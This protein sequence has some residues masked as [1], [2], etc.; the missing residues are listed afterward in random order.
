MKIERYPNTQRSVNARYSLVYRFFGLLVLLVIATQQNAYTSSITLSLKPAPPEAIRA[1]KKEY[2]SLNKNVQK[3]EKLSKKD[4]VDIGRKL[5][6]NGFSR[7]LPKISGFAALYGGYVDYSDQD[8]TINFPLLHEKP[9][10]YVLITPAIDVIGVYGETIS[11]KSLK[12]KTPAKLYRFE[13]KEDKNKIS[14]WRVTKK[15]LP[16]NGKI[17]PIAIVLL[18]KVKNIVIPTGDFIA[19]DNPN[20]SLPN[21]YVVGNIDNTKSLL[22]FLD[23]RKYF[24]QI[25]L[26][27]KSDKQIVQTIITNL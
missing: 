10:A 18:S 2:P 3:L 23:M 11:H 5:L 1:V 12:E 8:G 26:E 25:E 21:I 4:S 7:L 24:E 13:R 27:E 17:N 9:K 16:K 20:L 6:K 14:Y 22:N 15:E 19:T